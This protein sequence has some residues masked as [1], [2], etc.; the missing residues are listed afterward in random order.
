MNSPVPLQR[1]STTMKSK[2][3]LAGVLAVALPSALLLAQQVSHGAKTAHANLH[4]PTEIQ[5]KDGPPSLPPGA[6]FAMLEGDPTRE[7][8]FVMRVRVPDGFHIPAHTHPKPERVTIIQG[9]FKLA[10]GDNPKLA[11]ARVLPVGT[12]GVWPP[13]MVHAVWVEGET[14]VQFHGQGPW[15]INYVNPADDPRNAGK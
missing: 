10:M 13:G 15:I 8:M 2:L 4:P 1:T 6:K 3:I 9:T 11:D 12:Y 5:W 7:G 14:I